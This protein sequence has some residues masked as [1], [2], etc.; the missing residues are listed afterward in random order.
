MCFV[1]KNFIHMDWLCVLTVCEGNT[2]CQLI[3]VYRRSKNSFT[4]NLLSIFFCKMLEWA[5]QQLHFVMSESV[6]WTERGKI[7]LQWKVFSFLD[8]NRKPR[9]FDKGVE[10][11]SSEVLKCYYKPLHK[12]VSPVKYLRIYRSEI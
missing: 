11:T 9:E 12:K 8:G 5:I 4:N 7:L 6:S 1:A 2:R 3:N 10:N